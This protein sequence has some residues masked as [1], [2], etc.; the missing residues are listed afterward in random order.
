MNL[1]RVGFLVD[2]FPVTISNLGSFPSCRFHELVGGITSTYAY[3]QVPFGLLVSNIDIDHGITSTA[4]LEA[5]T[6]F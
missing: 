6:K 2:V 4:Y 5:Y 1:G 3:A